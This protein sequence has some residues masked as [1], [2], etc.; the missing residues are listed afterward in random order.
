M[1]LEIESLTLGYRPKRKEERILQTG[2]TLRAGEGKIVALLGRNGVGKSTLL[3][4]LAGVR[5][6]LGGSVSLDGE[7]LLRLAPAERAKRIA[8]VTT[9]SVTVAHLRVYEA[10]AMGRAPY[11]GWFGSLSTEDERRVAEALEQ[12]GMT[13]FREKTLD[14]LSDGERQRVMIARA[15]AQD[16]PV[17]L[18]DE[19]TAFLDLPNRYHIVLLLRRLAHRT[20]KIVVFSSH[21]L[22]VALQL[23]D[24]LWVMG[25]DGVEA[26]APD[27]LLANGA[28]GRIFGDLPLHCGADGTIRWAV[29]F[30]DGE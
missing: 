22:S 30:G 7:E 2:L 28:I 4:V 1:G 29:P 20:G 11:T 14:T 15:L 16:T 9:E 21:D 18:L 27:E 10:V 12:V 23:C 24:V 8:F 3:R 17:M 13:A 25:R 5:A 19:P 6:P 26:G